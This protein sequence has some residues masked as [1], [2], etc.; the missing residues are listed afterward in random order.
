[1]NSTSFPRLRQLTVIDIIAAV[2]R[3]IFF[4]LYTADL[5]EL[6]E[7]HYDCES[8]P[9]CWWYSALCFCLPGNTSYLQQR[10]SS[11]ISDI[12]AWMRQSCVHLHPVSIRSQQLRWWS[13]TTMRCL[14]SLCATSAS[15]S[16]PTFPCGHTFYKQYPSAFCFAMQYGRSGAYVVLSLDRCSSHA[17]CPFSE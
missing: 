11:C 12:A 5:I 3:P 4:L 13:A 14:S 10:M 6:V 16:T 2:L 8:S 9:V 15:T 1:M 7:S 17:T